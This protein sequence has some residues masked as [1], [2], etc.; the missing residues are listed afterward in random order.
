MNRSKDEWAPY[1]VEYD[2]LKIGSIDGTDADVHDNG[3]TRALNAKYK[4]NKKVIG[5]PLC[6]LFIARLSPQTDE[7]KIM[8]TFKRYGP[9]RQCRLVRDIVTGFSKCYAFLEFDDEDAA[10]SALRCSFNLV[11]DEHEV[12]VDME[13]ERVLKGWVPRRL[14]GGFGGKKESG[15]LR[16]GC[17]DR[18]FRKPYS[19]EQND[20]RFNFNNRDKYNHGKKV[21]FGSGSDFRRTGNAN[22]NLDRNW[23]DNNSR[24]RGSDRN[25]ERYRR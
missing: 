1:A 2:P 11:I 14:G 12:F 20:S 3:I 7:D 24:H 22:R 17:K 21:D 15:Q 18:P 4:P 16:F 10:K 19:I 9:I 13:C 8:K 25:T 23:T 6:T 5:D